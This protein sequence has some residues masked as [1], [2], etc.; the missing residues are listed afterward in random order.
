MIVI[1]GTKYACELCIRGHR[2]SNCIHK[3]R[4]LIK[5]RKKGRPST[6]CVHCKELRRSKNV[7]PSGTCQCANG[8]SV[9]SL[10]NCQ[11][12]E[13]CRCHSRRGGDSGRRSAASSAVSTPMS[14]NVFVNNNKLGTAGEETYT[15]N[16]TNSDGL[17]KEIASLLS[18][19]DQDLSY[20]FENN[21]TPSYAYVQDIGMVT[22]PEI[23]NVN[24]EETTLQQPDNMGIGEG[25]ETG[26]P[27]VIGG[28]N[29]DNNY[30]SSF[31]TSMPGFSTTTG[32]GGG[33]N[34][35]ID[36]RRGMD[37]GNANIDIDNNVNANNSNSNTNTNNNNN[38]LLDSII[39]EESI[40]DGDWSVQKYSLN[41]GEEELQRRKHQ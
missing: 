8:N 13:V 41:M 32:G 4:P 28:N 29:I 38:N 33:V 6:T 40:L 12:G 20:L 24:D 37:V 16:S 11:V 17:S 25:F 39:P 9:V 14:H 1:D 34:G 7:N 36:L 22:S 35:N 5:I 15:Y 31:S 26:I 19:P 30:M 18:E 27:Q 23:T 3:D 2:S 21:L 10:C